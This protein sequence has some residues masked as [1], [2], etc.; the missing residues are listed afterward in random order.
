MRKPSKYRAYG[1]ILG[2]H[3]ILSLIAILVSPAVLLTYAICNLIR[4]KR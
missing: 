1:K 4:R 3:W 2:L